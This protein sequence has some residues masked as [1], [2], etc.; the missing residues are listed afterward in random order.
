[1]G[2]VVALTLVGALVLPG[3]L[4]PER[5]RLEVAVIVPALLTAAAVGWI[6]ALKAMHPERRAN[7]MLAA[8]IAGVSVLIGFVLSA[9]ILWLQGESASILTIPYFAILGIVFAGIPMLATSFALALIWGVT[10][11]LVIRKLDGSRPNA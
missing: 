11:R 5:D 7:V 6:F 1:V 9:S 3:V 10:L 8:R 4:L 2:S